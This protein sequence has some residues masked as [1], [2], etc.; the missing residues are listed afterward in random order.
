MNNQRENFKYKEKATIPLENPIIL[1]YIHQS[2]TM[3]L[4]EKPLKYLPKLVRT[5]L[6]VKHHKV[7]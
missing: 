2:K 1:Y 5:S 6:N 3:Y 4:Y 7:M